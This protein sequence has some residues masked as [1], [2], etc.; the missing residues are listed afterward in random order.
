MASLW[1]NVIFKCIFINQL[2]RNFKKMKKVRTPPVRMLLYLC[3]N[4]H[5]HLLFEYLTIS[6]QCMYQ[7]KI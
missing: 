5:N 7:M 2:V 1:Y 3:P 6:A 4:L